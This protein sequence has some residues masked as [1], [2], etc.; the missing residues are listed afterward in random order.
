MCGYRMLPKEMKTYQ[1]MNIKKFKNIIMKECGVGGLSVLDEIKFA[2][3]M[4]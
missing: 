2:H 4:R 1:I 3:D